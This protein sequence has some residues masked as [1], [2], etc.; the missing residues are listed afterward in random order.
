MLTK[1]TVIAGNIQTECFVKLCH[2]TVIKHQWQLEQKNRRMDNLMTTHNSYYSV[3]YDKGNQ[4]RC[5]IRTH[6]GWL[7]ESGR[8]VILVGVTCLAAQAPS[9]FQVLLSPAI[10][11]T[12]TWR[13]Q[14]SA[15][16]QN[17][18]YFND[19][20]KCLENMLQ[21]QR[22]WCFSRINDHI[23]LLIGVFL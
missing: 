5:Q 4:I 11:R 18:L 13:A 14:W 10:C 2:R 6:G 3:K 15:G 12:Q 22:Y 9:F 20:N 19:H 17:I 16:L 1:G 7:K 23:C 8:S 21:I